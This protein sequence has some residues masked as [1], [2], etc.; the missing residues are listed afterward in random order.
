[1]YINYRYPSLKVN[2]PSLATRLGDANARRR[3]YL[4]SLRDHNERLPTVAAE[5]D[6]YEPDTDVKEQSEVN[7]E[8]TNSVLTAL[9]K[10][11]LF[12]EREGTASKADAAAPAPMH[13]MYEKAAAMS[14]GSFTKSY[15]STSDEELSFPPIPA[16][17]QTGSPILCPNCLTSLQLKGESLESEWK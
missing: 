3:Q 9:A 17:A 13:E 4:K 14:A 16:E 12:A 2:N 6:F 1:M 7:T 5:S 15:A 10:P 8:D 11:A